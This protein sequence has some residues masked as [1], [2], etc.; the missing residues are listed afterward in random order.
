MLIDLMF[1]VVPEGFFGVAI[2]V[3]I[4][5]IILMIIAATGG[6]GERKFTNPS[7]PSR[8]MTLGIVISMIGGL[9]ICIASIYAY[10]GAQKFLDAAQ[11]TP[12]VTSAAGQAETPTEKTDE[13][14]VKEN[15]RAYY[16]YL[17]DE[18]YPLAWLELF[19]TYYDNAERWSYKSFTYE[20]WKSIVADYDY[21]PYYETIRDYSAS[22]DLA[23]LE[24]YLGYNYQ[25]G[26]EIG[27]F[28][29]YCFIR[30]GESW[31]ISH[32]NASTGADC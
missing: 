4:L 12:T 5:G 21:M 6:L 15:L 24:M 30:D 19:A 22:G 31:K 27:S 3:V 9:T 7:Y 14:L 8:F 29:L 18:E 20:S 28:R 26:V 1:A 11:Q 23:E 17:F 10:N 25:G 2:G 13:D 32:I 16:S